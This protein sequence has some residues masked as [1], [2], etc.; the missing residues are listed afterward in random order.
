MLQEQERQLERKEVVLSQP[1]VKHEACA[2]FLFIPSDRGNRH[3]QRHEFNR[4]T[5]DCISDLQERHG[6]LKS[7]AQASKL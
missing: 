4:H 6:H 1:P 2:D 7:L 3:V 5:Q